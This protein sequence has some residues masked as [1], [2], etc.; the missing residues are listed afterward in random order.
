MRQEN[1]RIREEVRAK[2]GL[3]G[4]VV[5]TNSKNPQLKLLGTEKAS[6]MAA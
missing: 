6:L 5:E 3:L 2:S 4:L 1:S